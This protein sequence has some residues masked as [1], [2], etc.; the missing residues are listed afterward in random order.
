METILDELKQYVVREFREFEEMKK[1]FCSHKTYLR[2]VFDESVIDMIDYVNNHEIMDCFYYNFDLFSDGDIYLEMED[3]FSEEKFIWIFLHI[4]ANGSGVDLMDD[5]RKIILSKNCEEF[6]QENHLSYYKY[7]TSD[8][9]S[10]TN[11][12]IFYKQAN[13]NFLTDMNY[14]VYFYV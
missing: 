4:V 8:F 9:A 14:S 6:G 10:I 3:M 5:D 2:C 7:F 13:V 12:Q 11:R 1:N